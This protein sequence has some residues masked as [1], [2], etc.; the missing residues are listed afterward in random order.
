MLHPSARLG[1]RRAWRAALGAAALAA[2]AACGGGSGSATDEATAVASS[3]SAGEAAADRA[4]GAVPAPPV[5]GGPAPAG[6]TASAQS[7]APAPAE[8]LALSPAVSPAV[9]PAPLPSTTPALAAVPVPS[10]THATAARS[11]I[12]INLDQPTYWQSDWPFINELK[13][14]G[15]WSTRCNPWVTPDTCT[16]FAAGASSND[17]REQDQ[18]AWDADGYATRLPAAN[19]ATVKYRYLSALLFQGNGGSHPAGRYVVLYDGNGTIEYGGAGRKVAAE[20]T[21]GRDVLDVTSRPD[22]PLTLAITRIDAANHLR[23]IRVIGPGGVCAGAPRTWVA[24][25]AACAPGTFQSLE[26]LSATQTFHPAYVGDLSGMRALRFMKWSSANTSRIVNWADRPLPGDALWNTEEGVPYEAM[27][28]LARTSGADPWVNVPPFVNDEFARQLAQLAKRSLAPGA[29]LYFEYG[30]E[31]WNQ[32]PPYSQAGVMF[33][34][35]ARAKWPGATMPM[36]QQRLNWYAYRSVQLCR[37]VK[38]EFGAEASRVKCVANSQAANTEV[39]RT[40][41][42][43]DLAKAELGNSCGRQLDALA[44]APYFGYYLSD[45]QFATKVEAWANEADGGLDKVFREITGRDAAGN[46]VTPP[47]YVAGG[48]TPKDG[49]LAETRRWIVSSKALADTYGIP[50]VAYEA[51]QHLHTYRGG[52]TE[53]MFRAANRDPRMGAAMKQL[54]DDWE[55][56]GG[57]LFVPFSYAQRAVMGG[58]WGMKEHQRDDA[59]PKWQAIQA[60]RDA[61]CWWS[62]CTP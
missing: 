36:W 25:A 53:A 54:A 9:S 39:S 7:P 37:A 26:A 19:D 51:G 4:A 15:G 27:F 45:G 13:R 28:E 29:T 1:A 18:V 22:D 44:I 35:K 58:A 61:A 12:G 31:P 21:P 3:A 24:D 41:L 34:E 30:N 42:A 2:L 17:T 33:E 23:N 20:S 5:S 40:I 14:A 56:A 57:Q 47:L 50:M 43:C 55:A 38:A 60:L 49:S 48:W 52:K 8:S 6:S 10:T 11:G 62:G 16:G 59:A 46:L 32:A